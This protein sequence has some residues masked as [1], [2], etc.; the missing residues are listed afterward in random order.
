[1]SNE[2]LEQAKRQLLSE[3]TSLRQLSANMRM[4]RDTLKNEIEKICTR[5]EKQKLHDVLQENKASCVVKLDEQLKEIVI[6]ILKGEISARQAADQYGINRETLRRKVD[7]LANS[8]SEYIQYYIRYKSTRGDYSGINFR[9]L[10]IEM[11][12]DNMTQTDIAKKY[13]IPVRTMS[14]ELEK[15]G[16]SEDEQDQKLYNIAKIYAGRMMR[17]EHLIEYERSLYFQILE[18]I[19]SNFAFITVD[20]GTEEE[21][22]LSQ[23][24]EFKDKVESLAEQG[25][26]KQEIAEKLGIGVSTI[27][28]RLLELKELEQLRK[29]KGL[30]EADAPSDP[31]E[32][33]GRE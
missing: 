17:K 11:I 15:L 30:N 21:K 27:R 24:Q 31:E 33:D 26:P 13:G 22:R 14:R 12:E 23:L 9:R 32:P 4:D 29:Q 3:Q 8:S 1:M 18:E 28:R 2:E 10:F 5:E 19:K 16:K 20:C 7:E 6:R 25:M